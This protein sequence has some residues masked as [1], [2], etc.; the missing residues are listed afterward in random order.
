MT[1]LRWLGVA[2]ALVAI[3]VVSS[4]LLINR[5][6]SPS[7]P[8][9]N[10]SG[11]QDEPGHFLDERAGRKDP[12]ADN[13]TARRIEAP[14]DQLEVIV[15]RTDGS[16]AAHSE[17]V[18]VPWDDSWQVKL[19]RPYAVHREDLMKLAVWHAADES[20]VLR[21]DRP[22]RPLVIGARAD[23]FAAEAMLVGAETSSVEFQLKAGHPLQIYSLDHSNNRVP[24]SSYETHIDIRSTLEMSPD[25]DPAHLVVMP[26]FG[27][28]A[29]AGDDAVATIENLADGLYWVKA[30]HP[31]YA[32]SIG[33]GAWVPMRAGAFVM[34][35]EPRAFVDGFVRRKKDG[36]PLAGARVDIRHLMRGQGYGDSCNFITQS[37]GYFVCDNAWGSDFGDLEAQAMCWKDGFGVQTIAVG[38]LKVGERK[39]VEFLLEESQSFHG[40][41]VDLAGSTRSGVMIMA[42]KATVALETTTTRADGT[43]SL[44]TLAKDD[45]LYLFARGEGVA[46]CYSSV[47]S[48]WPT[49]WP[50][51][52]RV[53]PTYSILGKLIADAYPLAGARVRASLEANRVTRLHEVWVDA[54]AA[55]GAFRF[56]GLPPGRYYFDAVAKGYSPR[57]IRE[58]EIGDKTNPDTL[59]V[60]LERGCR[61]RGVVRN[62]SNGA[63]IEGARVGLADFGEVDTE[64]FFG[65]IDLEVTTDIEGRFEIDSVE[66]GQEMAL[67]IEKDGFA[68]TVDRFAVAAG[69]TRIERTIRLVGGGRLSVSA[70]RPDGQPSGDF[71]VIAIDPT[72]SEHRVFGSVEVSL[73]GLSPTPH[74]VTV[75]LRDAID[76]FRGAIRIYDDVLIRAGEETTLNATFADGLAVRGS[77]RGEVARAYSGGFAAFAYVWSDGKWISRE[78][79]EVRR[80]DFG[81]AIYGLAPGT[82]KISVESV[83]RQPMLAAARIVELTPDTPCVLDF[84]FGDRVLEGWVSDGTGQPIGGAALSFIFDLGEDL[85]NASGANSAA[86]STATSAS[87]G[88]YAV[89]GLIPGFYRARVDAEGYARHRDR[90]AVDDRVPIAQ[91]DFALDPECRLRIEVVDRAG[92]SVPNRTITVLP[93]GSERASDRHDASRLDSDGFTL[94]KGVGT[95]EYSLTIDAPGLFRHRSVIA[96]VAGEKRD[97]RVALR[98]FAP[99]RVIARDALGAPLKD[100]PFQIID[101]ETGDEVSAWIADGRIAAAVASTT[102][103]EKGALNLAALPEGRYRILGYGID[104]EVDTSFDPDAKPTTLTA[105]Q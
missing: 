11:R 15:R 59:E 65:T 79:S 91:H 18:V 21:I 33:W 5:R 86:S 1:R 53:E 12:A 94:V 44:H 92:S 102:T 68:R 63:P 36:E 103:D 72:G 26:L 35:S 38:F 27:Y 64:K 48:P 57:R 34:S 42:L 99:L 70:I 73:D 100:V 50:F 40:R 9:E 17:V 7:Q 2:V 80:S 93:I 51:V 30:R 78:F 25:I 87:D 43:F 61:I 67:S 95:G 101:V 31:D 22:S 60:R 54:D 55:T 52:I 56:E 8:D 74:R 24:G 37:D 19:R 29:V 76:D 89:A 47:P 49:E 10:A 58:I 6:A 45:T 4:H 83:D 16:P 77:I 32:D 82:Y 105:A 41:V 14:H 97:L 13:S 62:D 69:A 66:R 75:G 28:R 71:N 46:P 39:R 98:R 85:A 84:E 90:I 104:G 3:L 81:F 88:R 23:G 96:C 20:G